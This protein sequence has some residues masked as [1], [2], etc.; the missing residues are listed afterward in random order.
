MPAVQYQPQIW[1]DKVASRS[2]KSFLQVGSLNQRPQID[3]SYASLDPRAEV[4][5]STGPQK[6]QPSFCA[7]SVGQLKP[8]KVL[9]D[10]LKRIEEA[11]LDLSQD[12]DQLER[13]RFGTSFRHKLEYMQRINQI[14][15][16][17]Q[18]RSTGALVPSKSEQIHKA[19]LRF[20]LKHQKL[21]SKK[22]HL[23]DDDRMELR[24]FQADVDRELN[25][26]GCELAEARQEHFKFVPKKSKLIRIEDDEDGY[27][28]P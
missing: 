20:N 24:L 22:E 14:Q 18:K 27:F 28:V 13:H 21:A 25:D 12:V 11:G 26:F 7:S 19:L 1:A 3:K 23:T 8:K 6:L 4:L 5:H 10:R 2:L 15:D 17:Y 9:I 16:Y